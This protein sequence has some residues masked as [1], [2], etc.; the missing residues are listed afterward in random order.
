MTDDD[1][2][3]HL[4]D[5]QRRMFD[6]AAKATPGPWWIEQPRERVSDYTPY[7]L[8]YRWDDNFAHAGDRARISSEGAF[9]LCAQTRSE[10]LLDERTT[11]PLKQRLN[12]T[13]SPPERQGK[14]NRRQ[15][16]ISKQRR[17]DGVRWRGECG[18]EDCT[19]ERGKRVRMWP[20][21][22][23]IAVELIEPRQR[24]RGRRVVKSLPMSYECF[25]NWLE[26]NAIYLRSPSAAAFEWLER[27]HDA[28]VDVDLGEA[29]LLPENVAP[30]LR[31]FESLR[32]FLIR[33]GL[34]ANEQAAGLKRYLAIVSDWSG[35][36][37]RHLRAARLRAEFPG[38]A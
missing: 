21:P 29:E 18:C 26:P 23:V 38:W 24:G 1:A 30:E 31:Q 14:P 10:S 17:D 2:K 34:D 36:K 13:A 4:S 27:E 16:R 12:M 37:Y 19:D 9:V 22:H 8:K 15:R 33:R 6:L 32:L 35:K 28:G 7:I 3:R 5:E 25:V 11:P 20:Q